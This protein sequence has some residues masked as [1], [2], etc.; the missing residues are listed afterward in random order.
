[1]SLLKKIV[2]WG[3]PPE[4]AYRGEGASAREI[5]TDVFII[6]IYILVAAK[7]DCSRA[8]RLVLGL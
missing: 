7:A 2:V 8:R 1:M 6:Y 4:R 3:S 5:E